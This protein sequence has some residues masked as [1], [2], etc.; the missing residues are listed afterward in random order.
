[1]KEDIVKASL[2]G[3]LIAVWI[4]YVAGEQDEQDNGKLSIVEK[5]PNGKYRDFVFYIIK[6]G[7]EEMAEWEAWETAKHQ[8]EQ[9]YD[10]NEIAE[11]IDDIVESTTD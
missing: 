10:R 7:S 6:P 1:M 3:K 8:Q 4:N 9:P 2:E 11:C 5:M